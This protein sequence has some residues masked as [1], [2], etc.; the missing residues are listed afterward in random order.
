MVGQIWPMGHSWLIPG[1]L[2][3]QINEKALESSSHKEDFKSKRK[4]DDV[5]VELVTEPF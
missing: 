2:K 1:K 3:D 5:R 4:S